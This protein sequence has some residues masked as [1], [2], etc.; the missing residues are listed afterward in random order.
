MNEFEAH[1]TTI[2]A[3][4]R[5][6][7]E[8][9]NLTIQRFSQLSGIPEKTVLTLEQDH[10]QDFPSDPY[11][12]GFMK[13]YAHICGVSYGELE[14]VW[15]LMRQARRSGRADA[16]PHNR[17]RAP[18]TLP[19]KLLTVHPLIIVAGFVFCY[20]AFQVGYLSLPVRI[21]VDSVSS[22]VSQTPFRLTG[23]VWGFVR[24][25]SINGDAVQPQDGSFSYVVALHAGPN[26]VELEA[27]NFFRFPSHLQAIVVYQAPSPSP[28]FLPTPQSTPIQFSPP[29]HKTPA[30]EL[31]PSPVASSTGNVY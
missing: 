3:A 26:V 23:S 24:S 13:K 25:L 18:G 21:S 6:A 5:D 1:Q 7:R 10:F 20:I 14:I 28:T 16:L 17:F 15:R 4:L 11:V 27:Q 22:P 19:W 8:A 31:T 9:A 30:I 29:L 2:G 12:R